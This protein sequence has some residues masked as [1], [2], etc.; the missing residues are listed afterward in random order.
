[1][2]KNTR[3]SSITVNQFSLEWPF[4]SNYV[5]SI[6]CLFNLQLFQSYFFT[7][8]DPIISTSSRVT[9]VSIRTTNKPLSSIKFLN[10][11]IIK[12]TLNS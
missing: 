2:E 1:M 7:K 9:S 10:W 5:E 11:G 8:Y 4:G 3:Q 12:I 6:V